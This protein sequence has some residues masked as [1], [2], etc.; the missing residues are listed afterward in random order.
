MRFIKTLLCIYLGVSIF[1]II[2]GYYSTLNTDAYTKALQYFNKSV[3]HTSTALFKL[4]LGITIAYRFIFIIILYIVYTRKLYPAFIQK[5]KITQPV[6]LFFVS[7]FFI[8]ICIEIIGIPFDIFYY[9]KLKPFHII[10]SDL[11]T[12][13]IRMYSSQIIKVLAIS[14]ILSIC[15][16]I[17]L[18]SKRYL[19]YIPVIFFLFSLIIVFVYPRF[20]T[21]HFYTTKPLAKPILTAK[22]NKVLSRMDIAVNKIEVLEKSKYTSTVNAYMTGIKNDRRIVLYDT[23]INNFSDADII[24]VLAHELAH[25]QEEH[26]LIGISLASSSVIIVLLLLQFCAVRAGLIDLRGLLR[27]ENHIVLLI[28]L[29]FIMYFSKP[30]ENSI[31]RVM[32]QRA[33]RFA[34]QATN[35]PDAFISLKKKMAQKN[36]SYLMHYPLQAFFFRSHP[37][38]MQ[39]IA[40]AEIYKKKHKK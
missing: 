20:F 17:I 30:V 3:I 38:P 19:L 26:V 8:Q 22:I 13:L 11:S 2:L 10:K 7:I 18:K 12:W 36:K 35:N 37:T 16:L 15:Y 29:T 39:R 6:L 31:S 5:I 24:S 1:F 4:K 40:S 9:F 23:L 32:E 14:A 27:P 34:L 25:Y 21:P 33:D 28:I